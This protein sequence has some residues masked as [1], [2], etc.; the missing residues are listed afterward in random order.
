MLRLKKLYKKYL[1]EIVYFVFV[2]FVLANIVSLYRS[3]NLKV[4]DTVCSDGSDVVYFWATWC[5]VCKVESTEIERLLPLYKVQSYAVRS[6]D[7]DEVAKYLKK[8]RLQY[9]FVA[10]EQGAIAREYNVAVFP[11]IVVCKEKKVFF[12]D[13]GYT[14]WLTLKVKLLLRVLW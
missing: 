10:D 9:G 8:E 7:F 1:K 11:T 14:S 4:D 6:G 5:K 3:Y 2:A 13:V 12:V